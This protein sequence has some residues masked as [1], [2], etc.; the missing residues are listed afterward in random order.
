[1]DPLFIFII[2]KKILKLCTKNFTLNPGFFFCLELFYLILF[3]KLH[4][5]GVSRLPSTSEKTFCGMWSNTCWQWISNECCYNGR[6]VDLHTLV[7]LHAA[8]CQE[9]KCIPK[10]KISCLIVCPA[11]KYMLSIHVPQYKFSLWT[12]FDCQWRT[13]VWKFSYFQRTCTTPCITSKSM[14][15]LQY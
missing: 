10:G 5:G 15:L 4:H 12:N 11:A 7:Y 1:M 2:V 3:P 14:D 6:F 8:F 13:Q 9:D